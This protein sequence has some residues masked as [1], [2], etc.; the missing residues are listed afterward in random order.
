M[1]KIAEDYRPGLFGDWKAQLRETNLFGGFHVNCIRY[2]E[3]HHLG[4]RLSAE[5][6][7]D[8]RNRH[9][10]FVYGPACIIFLQAKLC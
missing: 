10:G 2:I 1:D 3:G 7:D 9:K 6:E 4:F 5:P 8:H